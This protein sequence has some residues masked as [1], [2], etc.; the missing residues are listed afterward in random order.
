VKKL[1]FLV[2]EDWYFVSH[3][4]SLAVAARAAGFEVVVATR[5]R[6]KAA[7]ITAAGIRVIPFEM[8]RKGTNPLLEFPT[9]WRLWRLYRRERPDLAHHV[10]LKPVLLGGLAARLAGVRAVV[11]AIAGLGMLFSGERLPIAARLL[12]G[13]LPSLVGRGSAI[14]QN[15][16]DAAMLAECGVAQARIRMICGSGVDTECFAPSVEQPGIPLVVLPARLL[17]DK[18]V[19]EFVA[20]ARI[21]RGQGVAARFA[22][23]GEPDPAN[24]TSVT[25][26]EIRAWVAEGVIEWW[27]HREDMGTVYAVSHVVCLPSYREGL[28]KSLLEAAAAGRPIV[29]TDAPGC[30]EIVRDGVNGFLVPVRDVAALAASLRRLLEDAELRRAMGARGR[31]I[32]LAE[33]SVEQV[34]RETLALYRE[35]L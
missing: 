34:V 21:L 15:P 22:L 19:A 29:A 30:R 5:V 35:L 25:Q 23:V 26:A 6:E 2:T 12:K 32:V 16:D 1:L 8:D 24:P 4:L 14:V 20:A 13:L 33:F 18:G 9:L 17:R 28:P 7:A 10:A 3:R 31:Q 11:S 27:G